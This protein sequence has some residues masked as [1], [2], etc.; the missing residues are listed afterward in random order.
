MSYILNI[1]TALETASVCLS[2]GGEDV[3]YAENNNQKEHARWLHTEIK[4][5]LGAEKINATNLAAIAVCIGPGSYTGLRSGL[6]AAKGLCYALHKP[7]ITINSL[8]LIASAQSTD[9]QALI[10]PCIDARRME[11]YKAVYDSN[12]KEVEPPNAEVINAESFSET[13][14]SHKVLFCGNG[15]SKIE[16]SIS[17][18]NASFSNVVATAK[19]MV[20]ISTVK[21]NTA[22]FSDIVKTDP[23]YIKPF[24]IQ[25]ITDNNFN[26]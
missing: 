3:G 4:Q 9:T 2:K 24:Y 15:A 21:Y 19:H 5:L 26:I 25:Q 6:S 10:C 8:L 20:N 14:K 12:L 1:D 13:L 18:I 7:L 22:D 11:V 17:S 23:L 16:S